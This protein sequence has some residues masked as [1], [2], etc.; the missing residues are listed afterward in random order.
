VYTSQWVDYSGGSF[1]GNGED[2]PTRTLLSFLISAVAGNYS[3]L[4]CFVPVVTLDVQKLMKHFLKVA[5]EL[6]LI[7][8]KVLV[9]ITDNHKV[10]VK[11]FSELSK[12]NLKPRIWHPFA[13]H[14]LFLL[15]DPVHLMK[16]F[17]NNFQRKR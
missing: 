13:S 7:G 9:V 17:F 10:N 16:N 2:G 11:L 14:R 12:G 4:V 5:E 6:E 15:F 8:F 1:F 3:D